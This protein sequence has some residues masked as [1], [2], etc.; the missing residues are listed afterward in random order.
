MVWLPIVPCTQS[1]VDAHSSLPLLSPPAL[2][3]SHGP[4]HTLSFKELACRHYHVLHFPASVPLHKLVSPQSS[5]GVWLLHKSL[6]DPS[7]SLN[8]HRRGFVQFRELQL[9]TYLICC[10]ELQ[11]QEKALPLCTTGHL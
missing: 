3:A 4:L 7:L 6:L 11:R 5:M 1:S 10:L 9:G 8:F 2:P